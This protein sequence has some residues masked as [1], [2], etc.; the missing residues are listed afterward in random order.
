LALGR[1]GY[2]KWLKFTWPLLVMLLIL[3]A[4]VLSIGVFVPGQIF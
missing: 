1:V 4:I 2:N 3:Y